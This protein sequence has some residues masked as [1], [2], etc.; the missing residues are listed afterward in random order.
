MD[1]E[2]RPGRQEQH[3][4]RL[5][6]DRPLCPRR[7]RSTT[8]TWVTGGASSPN[9]PVTLRSADAVAR[10]LRSLGRYQ[11]SLDIAR[12]VVAA[13]ATIGGRENTEW[14]FAG[15][16]FATALRKAGH[17]WDALQEGEHVLQRYR[18]YLGEEHAYT[19]R[20]AASLVN[21]RRAVGDLSGA[22]ELAQETRERCLGSDCPDDLRNA[23]LLNLAS[24]LRVAGRPREALVFDEQARHGLIRLYGGGHPLTLAA[25]I[26]YAADLAGSGRLGD[27]HPA[28]PGDA[29]QI[30]RDTRRDSPRHPD[31]RGRSRH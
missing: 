2:R 13:H 3:R 24:V 19:L 6:A 25:N 18:D 4:D 22:E 11:E 8:A 12:R 15:E 5:P 17:H 31:G 30:P 20:A 28:R 29:D 14:L 1:H 9:D 26:N 21:A 23:A 10:D 7:Y 27:A 16:G